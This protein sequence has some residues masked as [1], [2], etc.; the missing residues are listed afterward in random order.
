MTYAG[1]RR[2]A[3]AMPR[4]MLKRLAA[5]K[6]FPAPTE[7]WVTA[8]NLAG[9]QPGQALILENWFPTQTGIQPRGG[10][11]LHATIGAT[12]PVERLFHYTGN[13]GNK[14][15]A[16]DSTGIFDVTSPADPTI[17]PAAS[18][19]ATNGYWSNALFTTSGGT[20]L[21]V[22]NGVD[23]LQRFDGTNWFPISGVAVSG[24][25]Y[26]AQSANFTVG[27]TVTGGSSGA[28]GKILKDIDGGTTGT[29]WINVLTGVFVDNET[30]TDAHTGHATSNIPSGITTL[31]P[32]ITGVATTSLSHVWI[33]RSRMFFVQKGTLNIQFLDV[34][35]IAGALG[36]KSLGGIFQRGGTLLFGA[37]WSRDSG[38][39]L[40]DYCVVVT[41]EGE[42]AVFSGDDPSSSDAGSFDLVGRYDISMP[43][44]KNV[45]MQAGGDLLVLT[46]DGIVPVSAAVTKDI[47]ALS[48]SAV[49]ASIEPD[50][51]V[52]VTSRGGTPWEIAKW[53]SR[54]LAAVSIPATADTDPF[55]LFVVNVQTG[56]W[57]KYTNWDAR[58]LDVFSDRF[59]FGT[60]KGQIWEGEV[61][62]ADGTAT[63]NYTYVGQ[64][65]HLRSPGVTKVVKS[66]RATF[67][68]TT[69]FTPRLSCS[70][71]YIIN[72]PPS[73]SVAP[74]SGVGWDL[75]LWDVGTWDD[76]AASPTIQTQW[77]SIG[78]TGFAV[79]PQIQMSANNAVPLDNALVSFDLLYEAG[80]VQV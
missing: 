25:P 49:S 7:G 52:A 78:V 28:T 10:R 35:S 24:L 70:T 5:S 32:A 16:A 41:T 61:T 39:G 6:P 20:F 1:F 73:P 58:S 51:K 47:A 55:Y 50:W 27:D 22:C 57:C 40:N 72:L 75:S 74:I 80:G 9:A 53:P 11:S 69:P 79:N 45:V 14:L 29:L 18:V 68:G 33:H 62:G 3:V 38:N 59:F 15:F 43:M 4:W 30:L 66:M 21:T 19:V 23:L 26:D 67:K 44:G 34:D 71:D 31:A 65:D 56:K 2:Q 8:A 63:I 12:H 64:A 36:Q 60:R 76:P 42:L 77:V 54:N 13:A 48:L 17:A 46:Q 37:T